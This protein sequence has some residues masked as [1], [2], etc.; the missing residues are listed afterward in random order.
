MTDEN[1]RYTSDILYYIPRPYS[2]YYYTLHCAI[3]VWSL[4]TWSLLSVDDM[5]DIVYGYNRNKLRTSD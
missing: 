1:G 4:V 3:C 5:Y 2:A